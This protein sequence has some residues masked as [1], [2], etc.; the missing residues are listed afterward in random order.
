M[1]ALLQRVSK[2]EVRVE[3]QRIASIGPGLLI[4]LGVAQSDT[5]EDAVWLARKA[6]QL[7]IFEDEAGKLNLSVLET[8]GEALVVSQFTL[9]ADCRKGR[10]P[11]FTGAARPDLAEAL[12]ERF[13]EAMRGEGVSVAQGKFQAMM[14]VEL[15]NAGP[16][17]ILLETEPRQEVQKD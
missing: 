16:V 9:Y 5:T 17:T 15:V 1:R 10:R 8:G 4:L 6:A 13:C 11:S 7:R 3:G 12:Y 14:E 2:A